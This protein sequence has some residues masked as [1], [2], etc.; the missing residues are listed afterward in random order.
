VTKR[1]GRKDT[2]VMQEEA[3]AVGGRGSAVGIATV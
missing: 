1:E 2:L 3:A